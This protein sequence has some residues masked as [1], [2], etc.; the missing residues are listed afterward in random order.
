MLGLSIVHMSMIGAHLG[1]RERVVVVV[2]QPEAL[3]QVLVCGRGR[4]GNEGG[5]IYSPSDRES[6]IR[7]RGN[8]E[9]MHAFSQLP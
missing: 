9:G 8:T 2:V 1:G 5:Q 6:S 4:G 7:R 3:A